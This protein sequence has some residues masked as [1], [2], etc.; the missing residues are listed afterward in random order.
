MLAGRPSTLLAA[1]LSA[2]ALSACSGETSTGSNTSASTDTVA[3][4][5]T[6]APAARK[7]VS[8]TP[9]L[10]AAGISANELQGASYEPPVDAFHPKGQVTPALGGR[11]IMHVSSEPPNLNFFIENSASIRWVLYDVHAGLLAFDPV[12][13]EYELDAAQHY[14]IED[15]L[16]LT[17][18]AGTDWSGS[19]FA[20]AVSTAAEGQ[21]VFGRIVS[22]DGD[23]YVLE[24]GS[25]FHDMAR[26]EVPKSD[27]AEVILGSVYT[28]E[29]RDGVVWHDGHALDAD[30]LVFTMGLFS[31]PN[32]DC[33]EKRYKYEKI[34]RT[35]KVSDGVVRFFWDRQ[36]FASTAAFGF[37]LCIL[38]SHLY[39]LADPDN[40]DHDASASPEDQGAYV[41][42][43]KHNIDWVGLGPYRV[44]TFE[45]GQYIE[46]EK[47]DTYWKK[48]PRESGYLDTIRWRSI[49][50][51]DLAFQALLNDE[52]DIFYRIK[53][54][55]FFGDL[56]RTETFEKV[57]YKALT[58]VGNVGY[59]VWNMRRPKLS[60]P[61]VRTALSHAFDIKNW[62]ATNYRGYALWSTGTQF[63]FGDA[64]NHEVGGNAYDPYL[65]EDLLSEAGWYDRDG[66]GIVDKDGEDLV[67][68]ILMPSGNKA[69]EKLLQAFQEAYRKVGV[70]VDIQPYEWATFLE[71]LLDRDFDAANLAWTLPD[72][73][74]D[75][76]QLWHSKHSGLRS[77]NHSGMNDPEIDALID[78][79]Q[80]ELDKDKRMEIW[81]EVH[82]RIYD[83]QP[84]L[85]GWNVPRKIAINKKLHGLK[86]YKFEPGFRMQDLY[87]EAGTEG[88]RPLPPSQ[89]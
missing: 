72:P 52:I 58:Y 36:Y 57:A 42:D 34:K 30:D 6:G 49:N 71:H 12:S 65:A 47:A 20:G 33:D 46:A 21:V 13:W 2:I 29:L 11:G 37:D 19:A 55:D 62:I 9:E 5:G 32:V 4:S 74:S 7:G 10:E 23:S 81:H 1:L 66:N 26:V 24:S 38:P 83:L 87:Y 44:T 70:K 53:S 67:I 56:T 50:H 76:E 45:R 60:D 18:D 27:V 80:R 40:S 78:A 51:D 39:N 75:P 22:D 79:G 28:F 31:N 84:Y 69:S 68:E 89:Q 48:D 14:D 25:G 16:L 41:N 82:Q 73:E 61:R 63:W 3:D 35:D 86:L 85:L 17:G 77:S 64:Y 59:T 15:Q 88:T 43:N 8:L 54:E